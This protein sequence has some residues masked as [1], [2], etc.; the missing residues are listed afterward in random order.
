ME[1][2]PKQEIIG[3]MQ[4]MGIIEEDTGAECT[5]LSMT[6][7]YLSVKHYLYHNDNDTEGEECGASFSKNMNVEGLIN[8]ATGAI[9]RL[10]GGQTIM[11]PSTKWRNVFDAV[12]FSMAENDSWQAFDATATIRLNT[13]DALLFEAS[14]DHTLLELITALMNDGEGVE[15]SIFVLPTGA[16]ALMHII[17]GQSITFWF[18]N[19]ALADEVSEAYAS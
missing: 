16:P 14:D 8:T 11:I 9:N 5:L 6:G 19:Q 12:A 17:P 13:K 2:I 15:Q 4:D 10:H 3:L 18:G 7:E 1:F